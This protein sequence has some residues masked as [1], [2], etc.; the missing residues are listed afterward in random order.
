MN[1]AKLTTSNQSMVTMGLDSDWSFTA[2]TLDELSAFNRQ[3]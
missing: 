1:V 2:M 3:L